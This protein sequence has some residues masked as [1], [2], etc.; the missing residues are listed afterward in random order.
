MSRRLVL[1][2]SIALLATVAL[3][4]PPAAAH[5]HTFACADLVSASLPHTTITT[6]Q[7]IPAGII[8]VPG[9][10]G[11]PQPASVPDHCYLEGKINER[12]SSVDGKP[13]AIGFALRL[14]VD[15][16]GRFF[17]QGGGGTDGNLGSALGNLGTGQTDSAILRGYAV[18]STDAGH[19]PEP[20]PGIGGVLFGIDLCRG[21]AVWEVMCVPGAKTDK[22]LYVSYTRRPEQ[23]SFGC[24]AAACTSGMR[25]NIL[26]NSIHTSA[27]TALIHDNNM[28]WTQTLIHDNNMAWTST[29]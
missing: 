5:V 21:N 11:P 4:P 7:T 20:V 19:Q 8:L 27:Q 25:V 18:V 28:A 3:A 24:G 26:N 6:A 15:W 16:N 17:F 29:T 14:P 1:V 23:R 22:G 10:F 9:P 2:L 12:V 13:Y